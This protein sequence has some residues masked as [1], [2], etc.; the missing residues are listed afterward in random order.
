M[1]LLLAFLVG[2]AVGALA[3]WGWARAEAGRSRA[4]LS[5]EVGRY[6]AMLAASNEKL[7]LVEK[8][9]AQ[10]DTQLKAL[11]GEA[12]A[13]NSESLLT[14][15]EAKLAPIRETLARFDEQARALEQKRLTAIGG[16]DE[17]LRAVADGQTRLQKETGSLVTALRAPHVRGRWGEVQLRRV[18][19]L[20]GMVAHCDFVEQA[21]ERDDDG[22]LLRPDLVVKLPGGKSIVVDSKAPLAAYLDAAEAEDDE[23]RTAHLARHARLV[24]E[25]MV[26]L[27]QKR[28]WQQF[29]PA[30]EFVV[31][32]LGDE[33]WFR[34]AVDHDPLLLEAG[35]ESGVMPASPTT[36]IPLLRA[37]AYG[38]QQETV[39]ESAREV[40][41]LGRELYE[42]LGVFTEH[43]ASVGKSLDSATRNFNNAVG[44]LNSRVLVTARKFPELGIGGEELP[45][46]PPVPTQSRAVL[47]ATDDGVVELPSRTADAA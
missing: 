9:Q 12:I 17:Q 14:L 41:R 35:P 13:R 42:R 44:S 18:V 25:H 43:F 29:E 33:G 31:M 23:T 28:Y 19:E 24:R 40:G 6:E 45:D 2:L 15:A 30:P 37:V 10:W 4:V 7:A 22:R 5:A 46:V 27:G 3:L 32:F 11:T 34:A 47:A 36:L 26:K 8:S 1:L 20:A 21:S 38:W 16:I 39:A